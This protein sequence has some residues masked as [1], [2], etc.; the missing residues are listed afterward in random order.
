MSREVTLPLSPEVAAELRAGDE[1]EL[2]GDVL[3]GR[4]QACKRLY[5]MTLKNEPLPVELDGQVLYFVGPTPARPGEVIGSAGPTTSA[6][7]NPF[8]PTLLSL[9]IRGMIGKGYISDEVKSSLEQ[10]GG[11][12]FGAIGG[13][14]ALLSR[15]I[16][17]A[18]IIAF[19]ELLSEAIYRMRFYKFPVVVL[20]DTLG[21]DLYARA[22]PSAS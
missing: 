11:V 1:I 9:G 5:D 12:Y 4:D 13:T 2:I 18:E 7:M 22:M 15:S 14:G 20:H 16:Q 8:M 10:H 21:G 19:P 3:T 6:R 17:A